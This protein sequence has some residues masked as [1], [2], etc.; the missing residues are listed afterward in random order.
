MQLTRHDVDRLYR[1]LPSVHTVWLTQPSYDPQPKERRPEDELPGPVTDY[2]TLMEALDRLSYG[3]RQAFRAVV[4][5]E[6]RV[7]H[8]GAWRNYRIRPMTYRECAEYMD[9]SEKAVGDNL[10]RARAKLAKMLSD[11]EDG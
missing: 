4:M 2:L 11:E 7:W 5:G 10:R 6:V 8:D 1:R 3:Q 9:I